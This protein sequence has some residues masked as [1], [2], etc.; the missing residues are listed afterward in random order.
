[1]S[2]LTQGLGQKR[3]WLGYLAGLAAGASYGAAQT[4]GKHVTTE[5]AP[6]LVGT[7]FALLFGLMYISIM[8]HRHIPRDLSTSPRRGFLWFALSGIC[9]AGGVSLLYFALDNAPLVVVS[10]VV[11]INPLIT[12]VLAHLLLRRL[13]RITVRTM[14]GAGLVVLGVLIVTISNAV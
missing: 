6:P 13:E 4:V 8:F 5:F 3:M 9:S 11:A 1:M 10:P 7:A 2:T 12:L 14:L